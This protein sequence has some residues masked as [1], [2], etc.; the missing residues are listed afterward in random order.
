MAK[1]EFF[2]YGSR[3][4]EWFRSQSWTRMTWSPRPALQERGQSRSLE[5]Y[6]G[7]PF[8]PVQ[9]ELIEGGWSHD[10]CPLCGE[11]I[12]DLPHAPHHEG[13]VHNDEWICPACYE[14]WVK[15][16]APPAA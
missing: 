15:S 8:D 10:H 13:Y 12:S 1:T 14:R 16:G 2:D 9:Y 3:P 7:Q 11:E 6:T 5:L 4:V